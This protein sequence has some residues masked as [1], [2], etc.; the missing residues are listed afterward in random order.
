MVARAR[1]QA[2]VCRRSGKEDEASGLEISRDVGYIC[3]S[4]ISHGALLTTVTQSAHMSKV[5]SFH[6]CSLC[7]QHYI[8]NA[9]EIRSLD[10]DNAKRD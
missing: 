10:F 5:C 6:H 7:K 3:T 8:N 4:L 9:A 2:A 1:D